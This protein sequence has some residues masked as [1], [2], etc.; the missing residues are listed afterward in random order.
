MDFC[1]KN[2]NWNRIQVPLIKYISVHRQASALEN[3][4]TWLALFFYKKKYLV[5]ISIKEA[6]KGAITLSESHYN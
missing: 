1:I 2:K 6:I 3:S 4:S 5:K